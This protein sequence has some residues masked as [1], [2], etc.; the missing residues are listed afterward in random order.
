MAISIEEL[1]LSLGEG[2]VGPLA[3]ALGAGAVVVALAS[4]TT[5]PVRRVLTN[6]V[7]T[8]RRRD[9]I[10]PRRWI[11]SLG[12]G[13]R[14][15]VDEA[16]AEYEADRRDAPVNGR[17]VATTR[18]RA[19]TRTRVPAVAVRNGAAESSG[20]VDGPRKRDARGRFQRRSPNGAAQA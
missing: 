13:W 4:R 5:Q 6:G 19:R 7:A 2:A 18:R 1:A 12:R 9:P 16:R 8:L 15:L 10:S 20:T 11:D 3:V 17:R 14:D